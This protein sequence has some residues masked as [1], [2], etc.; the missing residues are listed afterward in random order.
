MPSAFLCQIVRTYA[1]IASFLIQLVDYQC[2]IFNSVVLLYMFRIALYCERVKENQDIE[3]K[4]YIY[5]P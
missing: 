3:D 4:Y 1:L 5:R 2:F